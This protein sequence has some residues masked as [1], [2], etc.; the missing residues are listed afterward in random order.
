[1]NKFIG[2]KVVEAVPMTA[3]DAANKGY[4]INADGFYSEGYEVTY[5]NGYKSWCPKD[6]FEKN[7]VLIQG[8]NGKYGVPPGKEVEPFVQKII[9]EY[10][11]LNVKYSKLMAFIYDE[12]KFDKLDKEDQDD[13]VLQANIIIAYV[14]ILNKR[15]KRLFK[16]YQPKDITK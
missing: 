13:L 7:N 10:N 12:E 6:V 9:D 11:E 4:R 1:M 15:L 2:V 3:I 5:K 8:L 16:K 14:S